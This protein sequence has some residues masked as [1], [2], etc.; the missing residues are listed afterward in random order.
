MD[1][2]P[3]DKKESLFK[4]RK[5]QIIEK[6]GNFK[7]KTFA[8]SIWEISLYKAWTEIVAS[9]VSS[10]PKL[11]SNLANFAKACGAEEISLFEK[12]TFLLTCN[13]SNN[14]INDDQRYEKISH[15]IKKFKLSCLSTQSKFQSMVIKTKNFTAYLDEF[16]SATYIFIII[17]NKN[18]NTEVL[19]LNV[20]LAKDN[21]ETL[22]NEEN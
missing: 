8:T 2:I 19:R 22:I 12:S 16:T 18:V 10:M 20:A 5:E 3:E 14:K 6:A 21:F 7:I 9:L 17:T 13:Y 11:E 1:L 4:K 15:I